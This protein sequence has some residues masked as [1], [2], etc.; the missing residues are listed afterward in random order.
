LYPQGRYF[1]NGIGV[2][3]DAVVGFEAV[4]I[5]WLTGFPSYLV[6][7]LKTIFLY[8]QAPLLR[9]ES[10]ATSWE[11]HALMVS[12]MNGK[13]MGGSFYMAPLSKN[14]DGEF[15]VCAVDQVSKAGIFLLIPRF[16]EGT[17]AGHPAVRYLNTKRLTVRALQGSI[18]A[19]ADG[20]TLCTEGDALSLEILP[21]QLEV[22][23][24]A[25]PA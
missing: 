21:R 13:R 1:G 23:C 9:I 18:A 16:L 2:G 5:K 19:H 17:Q 12:V 14:D 3:F 7:A 8:F 22:V 10:D 25:E 11:E 15:T 24:G 20:E 6:A 4:K